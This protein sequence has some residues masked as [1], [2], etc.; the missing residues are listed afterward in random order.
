MEEIRRRGINAVIADAP[1]IVQLGA[2]G[3]GIRINLDALELVVYN[4]HR[5]DHLRTTNIALSLA[6]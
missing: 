1:S 2:A 4:P 6:E 3:F 5:A